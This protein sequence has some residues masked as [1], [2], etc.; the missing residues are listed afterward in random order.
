MSVRGRT[1]RRRAAAS[2]PAGEKTQTPKPANPPPGTTARS[3]GSQLDVQEDHV[4][5]KIDAAV[6]DDGTALTGEKHTHTHFSWPSFVAPGYAEEKGQIKSFN[7]KLTWKGTITIQTRYMAGEKATDVSC[8][9]RG[10]TEADIKARDITLGF[11]EH[12]H[13][14]DYVSY[15]NNKILPNPPSIMIGM[16]VADYLAAVKQYQQDL[17]DFKAAMADDTIQRTDQVGFT[18][19]ESNQKK[20][21]YK[22]TLP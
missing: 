5:V 13:Q 20:T 14:D 2:R 9:G 8:Y 1:A 3:L 19:N 10:T 11:H 16:E 6:A 22:H 18:L 17:I 21:C 15:L 7:G 12:C 4:D